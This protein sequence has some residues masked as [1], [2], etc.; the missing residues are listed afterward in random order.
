MN[1]RNISMLDGRSALL[2]PPATSARGVGP[3]TASVLAA[4]LGSGHVVICA[5]NEMNR[6]ILAV[7]AGLTK[8]LPIPP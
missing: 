4:I 3:V 8:F 5:A 6:K 1:P 2:A 7:I